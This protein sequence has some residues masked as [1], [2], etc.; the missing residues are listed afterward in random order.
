MA[1]FPA[2]YHYPITHTPG[3][4]CSLRNNINVLKSRPPSLNAPPPP[5]KKNK[6]PQKIETSTIWKKINIC[7]VKKM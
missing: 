5:K 4:A 1:N 7:D 2:I 6:F 3:P